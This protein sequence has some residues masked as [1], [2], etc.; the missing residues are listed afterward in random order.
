MFRRKGDKWVRSSSLNNEV[1]MIVLY[2]STLSSSFQGSL[3]HPVEAGL[4]ALLAG[5]ILPN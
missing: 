2:F 3:G 5:V 4:D 1:G